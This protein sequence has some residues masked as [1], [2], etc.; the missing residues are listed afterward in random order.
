MVAPDMKP[1]TTDSSVHEPGTLRPQQGLAE[2]STRVWDLPTRLFHW[3][4]A[5]SVLGSLVSGQIGGNAM[6]W[7]FRFG[8]VALG[9]LV[10]RLVWGLVGGRWS[11]FASFVFAPGTVLR[12][13]RGQTRPGEHLEVGHNPLGAFSVFAVLGLLA[14][15]VATGLVADDEIANVGPL[16]KFVASATGLAATA[17]HK[18]W[19]QRILLVLIVLHVAAIVF[20]LVKKKVNLI[21]PMLN[22]D[23][24]LPADVPASADTARTRLAALA[25]ALLC[26]ALATWVVSWGA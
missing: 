1:P 2:R 19:G 23:K 9:L 21:R 7:H 25:L 5:A 24:W 6:P 26:A 13:L 10:F 16:N 8:Y 17:W 12:Y 18:H 11:R 22:G 3:A 15:Q 14:V 20:Y 4:L